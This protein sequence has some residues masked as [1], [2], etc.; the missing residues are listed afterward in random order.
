MS[1]EG[2]PI[3]CDFCQQGQLVKQM[4]EVPFR[5]L[6]DK[7]YVHCRATLPISVCDNCRF[8]SMD[9]EAEKILD[10]TFQREYDNLP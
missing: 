3:S 2:E 8:Q 1:A 7:G 4:K 10:A 5:Q 6:S 9:K